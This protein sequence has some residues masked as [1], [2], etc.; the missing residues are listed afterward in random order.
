MSFY[1]E[2]KELVIL[3]NS[4]RVLVESAP[5]QSLLRVF[6]LLIVEVEGS[7]IIVEGSNAEQA[8]IGGAICAERAAIVQLRPYK[9]P[10]IKKVV[11]VSDFNFPLSPGALCREYLTYEADAAT[12]VIMGDAS[13]SIITRCFLRDLYPYPFLYKSCNRNSLVSFA[14]N[15]SSSLTKKTSEENIEHLC[16]E[17]FAS[18]M[19]DST[20]SLHPLQLAAGVLF[21]DEFIDVAWQLKGLEY[22]C[23]LDPVSQLVRTIEQR[24]VHSAKLAIAPSRP[25][26]LVMMDQF[27]V[28]HAPFAQARALLTE[29][30]YGEVTVL[31]HNAQGCVEEVRCRELLP[32]K[33][34]QLMTGTDF[35]QLPTSPL[36]EQNSH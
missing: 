17:V 28:M 24:R 22:G 1:D 20:T 11:V 4:K 15:F 14:T 35:S 7:I 34:A 21:D 32:Y 23:T 10:I 25:K 13:S 16:S 9:N 12:P 8:Y 3:A 19:Q 27:G 29:L 36:T 31:V 30:G 26:C 5:S 2:D 33:V 18:V 6:C